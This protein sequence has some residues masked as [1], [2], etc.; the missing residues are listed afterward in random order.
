M[1]VH[2]PALPGQPVTKANSTCAFTNKVVRFP[3]MM[4][5]T[6]VI[7]YGDPRH[8]DIPGYVPCYREQEPPPFTPD[9]WAESNEFAI[10]AIRDRV[11]PGD[12]LALPG[13]VC[14]AELVRQLPE[15]TAFELGIGYPGSM[16]WVHRVFESYAWMNMTYGREADT[17]IGAYDPPFYDTVIPGYFDAEEFFEDSQDTG[18]LLF[19]GRLIERKGVAIAVETA[20]RLDMPILLAGGGDCMP[21]YQKARYIGKVQRSIRNLLMS[22]ATALLAPTTYAEPFGNIVPEAHLNGCPTVTTDFG[23]FTETNLHGI[24]GFRARTQG[25]FVDAIERCAD[26]DRNQ[27]RAIA[28]A[29][30]SYQAIRPKYEAYFE[31]LETLRGEGWVSD[32][33][34]LSTHRYGTVRPSE[35]AV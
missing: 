16:R 26:L 13:G 28:K 6:E 3:E 20:R 2:L 4:A 34:G 33:S 9:G 35:A 12:F 24:T 19:V 1:R 30:Y 8:D 31:Q 7:V 14:Q 17:G 21:E 10:E 29:N 15:V 11:E 25:E 5:G 22:S 23:A 18:Y 27:I 32:W